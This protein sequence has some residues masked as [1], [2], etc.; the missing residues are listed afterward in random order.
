MSDNIDLI[1][2]L[3]VQLVKNSH[4]I[5]EELKRMNDLKEMEMEQEN[6]D[7]LSDLPAHRIPKL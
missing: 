6:V 1:R 5:A 7:V 2:K 4:T 3:I